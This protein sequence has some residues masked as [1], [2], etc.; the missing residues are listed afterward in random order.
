MYSDPSD[1]QVTLDLLGLLGPNLP[2]ACDAAPDEESSND[3]KI[4][5]EGNIETR[6]GGPIDGNPEF[7]Q[8]ECW[9]MLNVYPDEVQSD[10]PGKIECAGCGAVFRAELEY[11]P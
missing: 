11:K 8:H 2:D 3:S 9:R 4:T 5:D 1:G 6:A 10:L 7:R